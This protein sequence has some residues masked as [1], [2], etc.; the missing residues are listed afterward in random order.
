MVKRNATCVVALGD[1]LWFRRGGSK[2]G[3]CQFAAAVTNTRWSLL[4][5]VAYSRRDGADNRM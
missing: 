2:T 4:L 1:V 3:A 5:V